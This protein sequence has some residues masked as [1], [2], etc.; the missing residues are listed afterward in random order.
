MR[1]CRHPVVPQASLPTCSSSKGYLGPDGIVKKT[2]RFAY[3]SHAPYIKMI[4]LNILHSCGSAATTG[5]IGSS[6]SS[7]GESL[8]FAYR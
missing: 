4:K 6:I 5:S 3:C 1:P 2:A 8:V 7:T